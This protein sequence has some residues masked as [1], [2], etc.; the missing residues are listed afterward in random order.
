MAAAHMGDA[1]L[2]PIIFLRFRHSVFATK[3][4]FYIYIHADKNTLYEQ[5][6]ATL[7]QQQP[8]TPIS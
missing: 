5:W 1:V 7:L 6:Y 4:G 2:Y 3:N 8:Q